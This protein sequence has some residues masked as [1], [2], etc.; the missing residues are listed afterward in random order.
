MASS[1]SS[2]SKPCL[3]DILHHPGDLL[4]LDDRLVDGL[5]KLLYQFTQTGCQEYL[6]EKQPSRIGDAGGGK[7]FIY[8]TSV[9]GFRQLPFVGRLGNFIKIVNHEEQLS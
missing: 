7:G 5:A 1:I 8:L 2:T 9:S 4:T 3:P 6:H